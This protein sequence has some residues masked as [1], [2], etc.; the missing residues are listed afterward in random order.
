MTKDKLNKAASIQKQIE[1]LVGELMRLE[2]DDP[3]RP[4]SKF[5]KAI[6][7]NITFNFLIPE[8]RRTPART[9]DIPITLQGF[10]AYLHLLLIDDTKRKIDELTNEFESL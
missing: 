3:A 2:Y 1:V 6:P 5:G 7:K 4:A 9:F 8:E 10:F